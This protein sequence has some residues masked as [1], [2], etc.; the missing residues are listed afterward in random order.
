MHYIVEK[1]EAGRRMWQPVTDTPNLECTV[2]KLFEGN[3]YVF[4]VTAENVVGVGEAAELTESTT[5][6][7]Q[8][9]E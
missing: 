7:S 5:P 2:G 9:C 1:R 3:E 4:R 8:F 6:R